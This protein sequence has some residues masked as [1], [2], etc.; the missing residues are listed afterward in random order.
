MHRKLTKIT[1]AQTHTLGKY[2][3]S[4][5]HSAKIKD[6]S[7][8]IESHSGSKGEKERQQQQQQIYGVYATTSKRLVT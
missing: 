7:N 1:L 5:H 2:A 6:N 3:L 4:A 8:N